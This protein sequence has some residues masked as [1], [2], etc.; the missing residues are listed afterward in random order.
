MQLLI[1]LCVALAAAGAAFQCISALPGVVTYSMQ[2][3]PVHQH[4]AW[5]RNI[6]AAWGMS[7]G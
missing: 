7:C 3:I 2:H 5:S 1:S 4:P 6:F